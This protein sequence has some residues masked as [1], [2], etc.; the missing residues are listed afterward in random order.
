MCLYHSYVADWLLWNLFPI[1]IPLFLFQTLFNLQLIITFRF[2]SKQSRENLCLCTVLLISFH[3]DYRWAQASERR[4]YGHLMRELALF[5][6]SKAAPQS[7]WSRC[8]SYTGLHPLDNIT[9]A[10][11]NPPNNQTLLQPL[12]ITSFPPLLPTCEPGGSNDHLLE[13]FQGPYGRQNRYSRM[14][15]VLPFQMKIS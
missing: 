15:F 5:A 8:I 3:G 14:G 7:H 9:C 1:L 6:S 2:K 10:P 13:Q 4:A 12:K 11:F